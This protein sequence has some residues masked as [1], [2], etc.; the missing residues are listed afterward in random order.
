MR[1]GYVLITGS[2]SGLGEELA[3]VFAA[4]G[5]NIILQGRNRAR[6]ERIAKKVIENKVKCHT[7]LGDLSEKEVLSEL[8]QLAIYLKIDC[9]INNAA[10]YYQGEFEEQPKEGLERMLGTN[11]IAPVELSR[12][13]YPMFAERRSGT[14]VNIN[15]ID[16]RAP[17]KY[18]AAYCA[19]KFGLRGFTDALRLEAKT[20]G[21][22]VVGV[23]LGGM[24]T[25]MYC[26]TGKDPS[27]CMK[28]AEVAKKILLTV[29]D[30]DESAAIDELTINRQVY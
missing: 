15:S 27:K 14:I 12:E 24:N 1:K 6:A 22:R 5:W 28:P 4:S 20:L 9:L 23:Y 11:L 18:C 8:A 3:K 13:V 7:Y 26:A 30:S 2:T 25:P 10:E 17:K 29:E 21:V 19:A 16:A